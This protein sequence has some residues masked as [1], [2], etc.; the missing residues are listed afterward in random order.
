MWREQGKGELYGYLPTPNQK[1]PI[2][3]GKCD[4]KFGASIGT[5]A[6]K[7]VPGE[8]THV[9]ERVLL[10]DVGKAN[11]EIEISI[12]GQSKIHVKQLTLRTKEVGRIQG[13]MVHT[14]FGG[15][16]LVFMKHITPI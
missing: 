4:V 14:F 5:G 1:L 13:A 10:N 9:T 7:F 2:C 8:W 15:S 3:K 6:W 12:G 16:K 11:G